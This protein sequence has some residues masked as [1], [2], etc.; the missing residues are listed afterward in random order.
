MQGDGGCAGFMA[1]TSPGAA[2]GGRAS[3]Q[4]DSRQ[5]CVQLK[6]TTASPARG[7]L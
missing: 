2:H 7:I 3:G 5:C 6:E 1:R 4:Q